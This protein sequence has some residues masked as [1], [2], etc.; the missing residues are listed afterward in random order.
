MSAARIGV[1]RGPASE[2]R[3]QKIG[4]ANRG[5]K[6]TDEVREKLSALRKGQVPVNRLAVVCV[7]TGAKFDSI[8]SATRWLRSNGKPKADPQ[9]VAR[10]CRGVTKTGYGFV[11]KFEVSWV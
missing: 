9:G 3:K 4:N 8:E 11:W 2:D 1:K 7:E 10:C 5:K 6:R